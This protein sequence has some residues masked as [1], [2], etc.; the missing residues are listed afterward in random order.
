ML[1]LPAIDEQAA[2]IVGRAGAFV[3][4]VEHRAIAD[5]VERHAGFEVDRFERS[6]QLDIGV[7][8]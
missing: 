6:R 1:T 8:T 3:L 7:S 5:D 4:A 2:L